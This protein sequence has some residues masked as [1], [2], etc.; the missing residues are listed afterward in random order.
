M[1]S[2]ILNNN[3]MADTLIPVYKHPVITYIERGAEHRDRDFAG[4]L[5]CNLL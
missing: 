3:L 5:Y 2:Y 4:L 1:D